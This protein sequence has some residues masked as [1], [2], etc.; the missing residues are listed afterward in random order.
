[1]MVL[2]V[3]MMWFLYAFVFTVIFNS[4]FDRIFIS[5]YAQKEWETAHHIFLWTVYSRVVY[6]KLS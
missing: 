5:Q 1:M 6:Y 3:Y 4:M 2:T